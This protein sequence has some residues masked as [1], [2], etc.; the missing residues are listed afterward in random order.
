MELEFDGVSGNG[1]AARVE[2]ID[3]AFDGCVV[4]RRRR[5]FRCTRFHLRWDGGLEDIGNFDITTCNAGW[6]LD[7]E[8]CI[9]ESLVVTIEVGFVGL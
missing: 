6:R 4:K 9:V 1:G 8:D 5:G 7:W 3:E 2:T